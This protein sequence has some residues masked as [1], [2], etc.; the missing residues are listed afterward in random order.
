MSEV[1][2]LLLMAVFNPAAKFHLQISFPSPSGAALSTTDVR[3]H[4]PLN[5]GYVMV[6]AF[7]PFFPA[8][9]CF[10]PRLSGLSVIV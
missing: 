7:P 9:L 2:L 8:D 1:A 5:R 3:I 10:L 4:K 6:F